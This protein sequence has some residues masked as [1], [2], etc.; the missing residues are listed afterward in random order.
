MDP[1]FCLSTVWAF[2]QHWHL[3]LCIS[4]QMAAFTVMEASAWKESLEKV[5]DQVW[6]ISLFVGHFCNTWSWVSTDMMLW[7][8]SSRKSSAVHCV[9]HS[10]IH[11]SLKTLT[12]VLGKLA[13]IKSSLRLGM[14]FAVP[15]PTFKH[16]EHDLSAL[17]AQSTGRWRTQCI[18]IWPW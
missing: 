7:S 12:Y 18:I 11:T 14:T 15:E 10:P 5:I 2:L 13:A 3:C 6:N 8:P 16:W 9:V 1:L 4:M 17:P